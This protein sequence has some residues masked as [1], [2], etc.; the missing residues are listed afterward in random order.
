METLVVFRL[1]ND[2]S[3]WVANLEAGTVER[4]DP[5]TIHVEGP[6]AADIAN[7]VDFERED[8]A[9]FT[10]GIDFALAARAR[11]STPSHQLFPSR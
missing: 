1:S 9:P 11:S 8:D 5:T 10:K 7:A 3:I 4:T 6:T 2:D